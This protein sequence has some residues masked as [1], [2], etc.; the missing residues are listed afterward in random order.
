MTWNPS[1]DDI[2][3]LNGVHHRCDRF[4]WELCDRDLRPIGTLHPDQGSTPSISVDTGS[5]TSRR[6]SG[7]KLLPDEQADVN[8][9]TDRVRAYMVLQNGAQFRLGTFLW[10][11]ASRP[12]RSWGQELHSELVDFSWILDHQSTRAFSWGRSANAIGIIMIFLCFRAGFELA[13][14]APLGSEAN[15]GLTEPVTWQPGATWRQ[16]LTDLCNIVGFAAPWFDRD[17]R[18]HLEQAPDPARDHPTV[19]AYGP[20]TRIIRDTEVPTDALISAPN[21]FAVFESGTNGM[22]VGR[23]QLPAT[24]PHSF[25]RRG[26]NLGLTEN[27]QGLSSQA[28]ADKT[29]RNMARTKG[30]ALEEVAFASTADPRHDVWEIVPYDNKNWLEKSWTLECRS[31]GPMRHQLK[32]TAYDV[33]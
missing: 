25:H 6:L 26:S 31:G 2:L 5:N 28:L 21:D 11:D 9:L 24:A 20:G 14:M 29:V 30:D 15:R 17:G 19:P 10:A 8:V 12:K 18:V 16:M 22:R 32:R 3:N 33:V 27:V 1:T 7:F 4:R 23:Y 13:D